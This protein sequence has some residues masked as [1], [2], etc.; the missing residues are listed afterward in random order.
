MV[1]NYA[2]SVKSGYAR[3]RLWGVSKFMWSHNISEQHQRAGGISPPM[4]NQHTSQPN[5][6]LT[7]PVRWKR[8][9]KIFDI[10]AIQKRSVPNI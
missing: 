9:H 7:P 6:G 8:L 1:G 2:V 10:V 5:G 4:E 3:F